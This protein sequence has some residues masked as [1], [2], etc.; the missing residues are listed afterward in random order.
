[1]MASSGWRYCLVT[2]AGQTIGRRYIKR[3]KEE[4]KFHNGAGFECYQ[5][6]KMEY[7]LYPAHT[8]TPIPLAGQAGP[9]SSITEAAPLLNNDQ[10]TALPGWLGPGRHSFS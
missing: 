8:G 5:I 2:A 4:E 1:M 7:A 9:A 3:G 6:A 10:K